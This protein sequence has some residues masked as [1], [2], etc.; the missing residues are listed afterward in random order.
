MKKNK[1]TLLT[2]TLLIGC[3]NPALRAIQNKS[4]NDIRVQKGEPLAIIYE[5]G[6]AMWTYRNANCTE[7]VF[8]DE[9]GKVTDF[10]QQGECL[11]TE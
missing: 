10:Y 8:F 9:R 7:F 11:Q 2:F 4:E 6:H 3:A 5:N 1:L